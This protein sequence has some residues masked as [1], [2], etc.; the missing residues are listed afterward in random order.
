MSDY[1][2]PGARPAKY[3]IMRAS[4]VAAALI[5]FAI[6]SASAQ[7]FEDL[8][9]RLADHPSVAALRH[10]AEAREELAVAARGL[11]DPTVSFG[12]NNVP[13]SDPG[14]DRIMMTNKAVGVRQEIPGFGVR[15]AR[16]AREKGE[17]AAARLVADWRLRR[18]RAELIAMLA[19]KQAITERLELAREQREAFD[20]FDALIRA[21][22]E[23]GRPVY[24]RLSEVEI[25]RADV[26]R[27]I[28]T[29]EGELGRIDAALID[30][31][32]KAVD[33]PPP[34]Q[35]FLPWHGKAMD[36]YPAALAAA[37]I[38]VAKAGVAESKAEFKPDLAFQYSYQQREEG[39]EIPGVSSFSGEDWFSAGV[40]F[41]VP[42]WAPKSQSPRLRAARARE[43]AAE[44]DFHAAARAAAEEW[45]GHHAVHLAAVRNIELLEE[46]LRSADALI[47]AETRN[48]ES[49]R[50]DY[51]RVLDARI[52]R[53]TLLSDLAAERA[54]L[55][56]HIAQ[57][58]S[59][60]VT[61]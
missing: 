17:A 57:A 28:A 40:T 19:R 43:S 55:A 48:Y 45:R 35:E 33:T 23:A 54:N 18:L 4:L 36:L 39:A 49:G 3:R 51:I 58:N 27:S 41:S 21:E 11:P 15:S 26:D 56:H 47:A 5:A 50:S 44:A 9:A 16:S 42:L 31:V 6:S 61:P 60:L 53:L 25:E 7:T 20:E 37:G 24:F 2:I 38:A 12:V 29:L 30:L 1:S 22:I 8:E 52:A 14:F 59:L 34:R 32:D 46:K 13:L 10:E